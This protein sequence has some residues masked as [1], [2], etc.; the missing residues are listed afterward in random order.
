MSPLIKKVC[1]LFV[2][3]VLLRVVIGVANLYWR[4]KR[5]FRIASKN[6]QLTENNK[7]AKTKEERDHA[8]EA[9]IDNFDK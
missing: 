2:T 9:L 7:A 6:R 1:D 8:A 4:I 5:R 3:S